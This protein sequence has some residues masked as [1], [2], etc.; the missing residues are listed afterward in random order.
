MSKDKL[1][2][3]II[4]SL[5]VFV[6]HRKII[7]RNLMS[8]SLLSYCRNVINFNDTF[9]FDKFRTIICDIMKNKSNPKI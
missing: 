2:L 7:A 5:K 4:L 8:L 9:K 3:S 6:F 1:F